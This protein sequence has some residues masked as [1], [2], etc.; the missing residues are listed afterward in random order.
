VFSQ[1]FR[2]NY[3]LFEDVLRDD[4]PSFT[5]LETSRVAQSFGKRLYLI[6]RQKILAPLIIRTAKEEDS[7]D[8]TAICNS[9]SELRTSEHGDHFISEMI[10]S[11][12][13]DKMCLVAEGE[14]GRVV[15]MMTVSLRMDLSKLEHHF[16]LQPFGLFCKGDFCESVQ[17]FQKQEK[18]QKLLREEFNKVHKQERNKILKRMCSYQQNVRL[19][20]SFVKDNVEGQMKDFNIYLEEKGSEKKKGLN[21]NY[22]CKLVEKHLK[23]FKF[24]NPDEIFENISDDQVKTFIITAGEF[25]FRELRYYGLPQDYLDGQG[26]WQMWV[27]RQI[28]SKLEEQR[29]KGLLGK[30]RGKVLKKKRYDEGRA[31]E[32]VLPSGFDIEPFCQALKKFIESDQDIRN[33]AA[34]FFLQNEKKLFELF[35]EKNGEMVDERS[36]QFENIVEGLETGGFKLPESIKSNLFSILTCFGS[37]KY[38]KKI[39]QLKEKKKFKFIQNKDRSVATQILKQKIKIE[40]KFKLNEKIVYFVKLK[41]LLEAIDQILLEDSFFSTR[42]TNIAELEKTFQEE[43]YEALNELNEDY[44]QLDLRHYSNIKK[45]GVEESIRTIPPDLLNAACINI[46]FMEKNFQQRANDFLPFIFTQIKGRDYLIL[47]QPQLA[48]ETPLLS[49]FD[50][51]PQKPNSNFGHCLYFF[52]RSNLFAQFLKVVPAMP[53][54]IDYLERKL[55]PEVA[56][57]DEEE[58]KQ[59]VVKKVEMRLSDQDHESK[60]K[61]NE[62]FIIET[63]APQESVPMTNRKIVPTSKIELKLRDMYAVSVNR[64]GE[65]SIQPAKSSERTRFFKFD[66]KDKEESKDAIVKSSTRRK[67]QNLEKRRLFAK[68]H[69][70]NLLRKKRE[71]KAKNKTIKNNNFEEKSGNFVKNI[72]VIFRNF[73]F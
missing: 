35:C 50:L 1:I 46:F 62:I 44:E 10:S 17:A 59:E 47:T 26:H 4:D 18:E 56:F 69:K 5:F 30:R 38:E 51:V 28:K 14:D 2:L 11:Q 24:Q 34:K 22:L 65:N 12:D 25:L 42:E 67:K 64:Y 13:S 49:N 53:D 15:G 27:R 39:I 33:K 21:Q 20:Q 9:Q 29:N 54:E 60:E 16:N 31:N 70:R 8:L 48:N 61:V 19:L 58:L 68:K 63:K 71:K 52:H 36:I 3:I 6:P 37:L 23:M 32:I 73:S 43:E 41:D 57:N 7:D 45:K 66:S 40:P 55:F 72:F